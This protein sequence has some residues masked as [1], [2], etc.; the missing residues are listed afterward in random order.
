MPWLGRRAKG[1]RVAY[2]AGP[3]ERCVLVA[4]PADFRQRLGVAVVEE[5]TREQP[6]RR[7]GTDER[8]HQAHALSPAFPTM[9]LH[10][11]GPL[12][13]ACKST[14]GDAMSMPEFILRPQEDE[15]RY[16]VVAQPPSERSCRRTYASPSLSRCS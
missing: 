11:A 5:A 15:I 7:I 13:P 8:R 16:R 9:R 6:G 4:Y 12:G 1:L 10:G 3:G 14:V 2:A